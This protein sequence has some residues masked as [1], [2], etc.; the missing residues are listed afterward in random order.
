MFLLDFSR[1]HAVL[2]RLAL[3]A[4][5]YSAEEKLRRDVASL[6]DHAIYPIGARLVV[7][8]HKENVKNAER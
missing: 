5:N 2:E 3:F 6:S 7:R 1:H 4:G 8:A